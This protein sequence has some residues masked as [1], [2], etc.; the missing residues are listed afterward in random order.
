MV[1][2]RRL[3]S[4]RRKVLSDLRHFRKMW[5]CM[6]KDEKRLKEFWEY[7]QAYAEQEIEVL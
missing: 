1:S 7:V 4:R 2:K 3:R 5:S 6:W